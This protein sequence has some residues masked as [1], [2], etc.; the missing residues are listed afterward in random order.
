M[1]KTGIGLALVATMYS[2]GAVA[3]EATVPGPEEQQLTLPGGKLFVEAFLELS[4]SKDAVFKPVSLAPDVWY[5]I[6]DDLTLGLVHSGRGATGVFGSYGDGVCFT[7]KDNGCVGG[8]YDNVGLDARYQLLRKVGISLAG[9]GGLYVNSFD[10]FQLALK[11]GAIARFSKGALSFEVD[12]SLFFGVTKRDTGNKEV[13]TA[14]ATFLY[15]ITPKV[16]VAAQLAL[17]LP[18]QYTELTMFGLSVGAQYFITDQLILDAAFSLP[19]MVGG[20]AVPD[21]VDMRTLTLGVAYAF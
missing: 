16:G 2:A 15:A 14:P 21:G 6:N 11:L 7:G 10:P 20:E 17:Y 1:R 9:D 5:G 4:L 8:I 3:Q 19:A 18:F 13:L 12:P